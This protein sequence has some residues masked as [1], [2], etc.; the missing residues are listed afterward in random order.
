MKSDVNSNFTEI[1]GRLETGDSKGVV[2][3]PR[4]LDKIFGSQWQRAGLS[5]LEH[6]RL[7]AFPGVLM[8]PVVIGTTCKNGGSIGV[9][10][11][12][13][14]TSEEE[15]QLDTVTFK[16]CLNK[17]FKGYKIPSGVEPEDLEELKCSLLLSPEAR[18]FIVSKCMA[19]AN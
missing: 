16:P 5:P 10:R 17:F 11:H 7:A 4:E 2:A 8:D 19:K 3:T 9:P 15:M 1:M 6:E 13:M 18:N 12:M 14:W